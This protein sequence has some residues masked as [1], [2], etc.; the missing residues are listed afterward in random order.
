MKGGGKGEMKGIER[1]E[2][3]V[4]SCLVLFYTINAR[5][6]V[7]FYTINARRLVLLYTIN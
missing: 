2:L 5:R 1:S 3:S 4:V 6:V 7:L